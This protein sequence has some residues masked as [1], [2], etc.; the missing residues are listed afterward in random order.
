[1]KIVTEQGG[2]VGLVTA[3]VEK[4]KSPAQDDLVV[5]EQL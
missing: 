4:L 3:R 5:V 2:W 1:M